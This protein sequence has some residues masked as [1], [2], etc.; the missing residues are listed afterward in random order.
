[1][2]TVVEADT[3]VAEDNHRTEGLVV[4]SLGVGYGSSVLDSMTC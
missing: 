2:L 4:D 1:M 3:V